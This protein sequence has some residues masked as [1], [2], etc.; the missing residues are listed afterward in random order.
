MARGYSLDIRAGGEL[1]L[2]S[3]TAVIH[4][5]GPGNWCQQHPM[6][7]AERYPFVVMYQLVV[8]C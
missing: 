3:H 7:P 5:P 8:D 6:G 1:A 2:Q 4:R